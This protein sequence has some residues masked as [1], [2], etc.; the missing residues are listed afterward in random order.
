[1]TDSRKE[2]NFVNEVIINF[3]FLE[4]FYFRVAKSEPTYV[5][6]ESAKIFINIYHGRSSYELGIEIGEIGNGDS[7]SGRVFY[8]DNIIK[9]VASHISIERIH[10][11]SSKKLVQK[12][13]SQLAELVKKYATPILKGDAQFLEAL[14]KDTLRLREEF[15]VSQQLRYVR[16]K[17]L[18]AWQQKD[19]AKLVELYESIKKYL[20]KVE[21][22]KL[23]FA[24]KSLNT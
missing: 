5:R 24:K 9:F 12:G 11:A 15:A 6:Y 1:M 22:K 14:W 18:T 19:Y 3:D 2:L 7:H 17:A 10:S 4:D 20:T 16:E 8:I 13:V 23:N 21:E